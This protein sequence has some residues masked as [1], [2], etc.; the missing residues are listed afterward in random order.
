MTKYYH[1]KQELAAVNENDTIIGKEE[2]WKLHKEG[3]LHRGF[4]A[5][6]H[7][8]KQIILQHRRH[9]VFDG[10]YDLSF[11]SHQTYR[12]DRLED[13]VDAVYTGLDREWHVKKPDVLTPPLFLGVIHYQAKDE[14][15]GYTEH[16]VDHI[17]AVNLRTIPKPNPDF[18]Y[19][20]HILPKTQVMMH[21]IP[22]NLTLAPWV[23]KIIEKGLL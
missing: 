21:Q 14:K 1:E 23:S 19:G 9:P 18:A 7:V 3:V 16:E 22:H 2:K 11:S 6:L 20:I 12:E 15:S 5:I 4:T 13:D 17:F 8:G 10:V